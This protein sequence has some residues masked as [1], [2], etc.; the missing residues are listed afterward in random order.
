MCYHISSSKTCDEE[1]YRTPSDIET[2]RCWKRGTETARMDFRGQTEPR[3]LVIAG[4]VSD[5]AR[6]YRVKR[7]EER[8]VFPS[9]VGGTADF[10]K[11][12]SPTER[13]NSVGDCFLYHNGV[14]AH[15]GNRY[16]IGTPL[17]HPD[18]IL[19][20]SFWGVQRG[21]FQ[22]APLVG[23]PNQ[24]VRIIPCSKTPPFPSP[25]F[26]PAET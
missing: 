20:E 23:L 12:S 2:R 8:K 24:K 9:I 15:G 18:H 10:D 5:G 22:K 13:S 4:V 11:N 7:R 19:F 26:S 25:A 3:N 16:A 6:R 1:E 14:G 17:A 21:F